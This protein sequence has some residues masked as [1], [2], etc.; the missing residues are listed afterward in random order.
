MLN[1]KPMNSRI[2]GIDVARALAVIGMVI[3]NFK[4][5]LGEKGQNWVK[6]LASVFDG[7]ASATFVVLAGVGIALGTNSALRNND[8]S[9]LRVAKIKLPNVLYFYL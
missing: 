4:V 6:L 8:L 9:K 2:I 1:T 3:V 5:V 7:K